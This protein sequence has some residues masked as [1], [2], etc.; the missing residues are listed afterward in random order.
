VSW[1]DV[2]PS[3]IARQQGVWERAQS[4]LRMRQAGLTYRAIGERLGISGSM[5][6][7]LTPKARRE[8]HLYRIPVVLYFAETHDIERLARM[9]WRI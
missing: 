4:A 1:S 5:A 7:L 8:R 2:L 6:R 3:P 9:R